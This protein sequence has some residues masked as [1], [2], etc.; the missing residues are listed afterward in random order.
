MIEAEPSQRYAPPFLFGILILPFGAA[1]GF[2]QLVIPHWMEHWG[3]TLAAIS[4]LSGAANQPHTFKLLWVPLIDLGSHR[5]I[6]YLVCVLLT[7]LLLFAASVLPDPS[8]HLALL[9]VLVTGAQATAATSSAAL[10]ALM[11]LTTRDS[12]KGR[13][14]GFYA[15]GNVGGTS[16]LGGL[17]IW[18]SGHTSQRF[19]GL[20]LAGIVLAAGACG[21]WLVEHRQVKALA[22]KATRWT[23]AAWENAKG[24]GRDLW[25]TAKSREGLTGLVIC[26]VPVGCGALLNLF[27]GMS[28]TYHVTESQIALTNGLLSGVFS[29][30]GSL[31]GGWLAD[32]MNR[33]LAYGVAGGITAVIAIAMAMSPTTPTTYIWGVT[34]YNFA[35]AIAFSAFYAM[36]LE[37]VSHGAAVT[38]KYTLFVAVSNQAISYTAALDGLRPGLGRF[39]DVGSVLFDGLITFV[40]IG[41]LIVMVAISRRRTEPAPA[42]AA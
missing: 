16:L 15:A 35:N 11:A 41:I 33:R 4:L 34:A 10:D 1:V 14:A 21:L 28:G 27:T 39:G 13:A 5:K 29:I 38:T 19:S 42:I 2:L 31:L 22:E 26:A 30:V 3:L 40:G 7:G 36:V 17:A 8:H 12:D 18:L 24:I 9:T 20:L 37:M 32:R 25:A 23:S 6:W